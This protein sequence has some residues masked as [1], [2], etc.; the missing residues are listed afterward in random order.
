MLLTRTF[1][2]SACICWLLPMA[3]VADVGIS[4]GVSRATDS[5]ITSTI[6]SHCCWGSQAH[7][8]PTTSKKIGLT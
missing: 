7:H 2:V 1:Y 3:T 8:Q 4:P 5:T 6:T